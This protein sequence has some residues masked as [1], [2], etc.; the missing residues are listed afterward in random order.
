MAKINKKTDKSNFFKSFL[1]YKYIIFNQRMRNEHT[2]NRWRTVCDYVVNI[3]QNANEHS[4]KLVANIPPGVGTDS[5]CPYPYVTKN[6]YFHNQIC[7]STLLNMCFY[8]IKYVY[9]FHRTRISTLLNTHFHITTRTFPFVI[10]WV[11]SYTRA[12]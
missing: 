11:F 8:I 2:R 3:P 10:L 12:R 5:S 9:S 4:A 1:F 7:V 6:V